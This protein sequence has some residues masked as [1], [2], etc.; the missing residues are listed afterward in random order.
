[1]SWSAPTDT[2]GLQ[3]MGYRLY[4]D[5]GA[6]DAISVLLWQGS[7]GFALSPQG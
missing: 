2:G 1:M 6:G 7:P 3:L 5:N 4:R